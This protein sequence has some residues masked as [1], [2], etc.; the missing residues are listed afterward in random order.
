MGRV[1]TEVALMDSTWGS[2]SRRSIQESGALKTAY[3]DE[4]DPGTVADAKVA[5]HKGR[6]P[7]KI[8]GWLALMQR[9]SRKSPRV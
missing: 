9:N 1:G 5:E 7:D 8:V 4:K 2:S 6:D 3:W